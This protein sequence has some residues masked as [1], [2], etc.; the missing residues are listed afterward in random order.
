MT[1]GECVQCGAEIL[2]SDD[3]P[4][5]C[6]DCWTLARY[7]DVPLTEADRAAGERFGLRWVR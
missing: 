3:T 6:A 2:V 5:V 7:P 1:V 4:D